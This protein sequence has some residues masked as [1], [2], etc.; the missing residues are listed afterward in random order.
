VTH[1]VVLGGGSTG[2]HFVGALRRLDPDVEI[3][4]VETRLVGGECTYYACIPTKTMLRSVELAAAL[5]HAPSF[6]P[7]Q[8]Q[9]EGVWEWRDWATDNW[10]DAAQLA[11]LEKNRTNFVRGY[12]RVV[13]PGVIEIE[14]GP[15]LEYDRLVI[16]TG[17]A[18]AIPPI[19]GLDS[20]DYWTNEDAA[21]TGPPPRITSRFGIEC[22]RAASSFVQ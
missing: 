8:P 6:L 1:A 4:L 10:D 18:P 5:E 11:F 20:V 3:T 19:D 17:S 21:P 2:E 13:R 9:E 7:Q 15:E 14:D 22:V 12:G 16:A